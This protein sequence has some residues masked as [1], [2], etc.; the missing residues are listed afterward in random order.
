MREPAVGRQLDGLGREGDGEE[1]P[2]H[3]AEPA[4]DKLLEVHTANAGV[5]FR[6]PVKVNED[7]SRGARVSCAWAFESFDV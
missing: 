2:Q 3:H 1:T 7:I 5:K 4:N 6:A